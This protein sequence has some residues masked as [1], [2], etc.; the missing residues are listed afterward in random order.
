MPWEPDNRRHG[1]VTKTRHVELTILFEEKSKMRTSHKRSVFHCPVTVPEVEGKNL[2][3]KTRKH[4]DN[5]L[6]V[7]LG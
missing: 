2:E 4:I 1:E 5:G 6:C 3:L 7:S